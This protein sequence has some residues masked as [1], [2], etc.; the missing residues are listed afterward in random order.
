MID[1]LVEGTRDALER[2]FGRRSASGG[3]GVVV[4]PNLAAHLREV[5]GHLV[6][7]D[8]H[9]HLDRDAL[10]FRDTV[11]VHE[12]LGLVRAVGDRRHARAGQPLA[13]LVDELDAAEHGV[14]A[15]ALEQMDETPLAGLDRRDLCT[16]VSHSK[17]REPHV[18][19]DDLG[20]LEVLHAS[21]EYLDDR[22]LQPLGED[23]AGGA[24]QHTAHILPV[25]HG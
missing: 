7:F 10:A 4:A 15:V 9:A 13:L 21:L 25:G 17:L 23:V 18:R 8:N 3:P 19:L 1:G 12:R 5:D 2:Y 14:A 11:V 24:A 6:A 20:Q 16:K 22:Q